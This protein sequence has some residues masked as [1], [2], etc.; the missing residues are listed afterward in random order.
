M[1]TISTIIPMIMI[2]TITIEV[3]LLLVLLFVL[4]LLVLVVSLFYVSPPH[5]QQVVGCRRSWK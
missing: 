1:I 2:I 3:L 4:L 5:Q